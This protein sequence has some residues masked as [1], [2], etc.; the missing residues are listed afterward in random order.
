M[1]ATGVTFY[2]Y[3]VLFSASG[4]A[5]FEVLVGDGAT[6]VEGFTKKA[7]RFNST[8][9]PNADVDFNV[10]IKIV[11]TATT[12]NI[13]IIVENKDNAVQDLSS[14]IVGKIA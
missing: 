3:Q 7:V 12:T 13:K 6:P 8:A 5:R 4:R 2:L 14:T 9:T 10:P 11:G 1:V